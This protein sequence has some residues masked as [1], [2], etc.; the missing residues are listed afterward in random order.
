MSSI[1]ERL[2]RNIDHNQ[3][4]GEVGMAEWVH[5]YARVNGL[6]MHY[7]EQGEGPL[8]ILA[9]GFPQTW[10]SWHH[11]IPAIAAAGYR[12]VAFDQR[13]M[14]QTSAPT[15]PAEYD[16][17]HTAGDLVGLLDHL[18]EQTA[19]FAGLDFGLFAIYD[20]AYH[21]PERMTAIIGLENPAWPHD[22][23]RSPLA[24]AADMGARHFYHLHYFTAQPGV[25]DAALNAAP[26]AFLSK[27]FYALSGD[28]HYI[29]VWKHPPETAY[30]EALPEPP[31]LP[32]P[33]LSELEL[34]F[35]VNDYARSGF[36]G[37]LN[38]YRA[39]DLRW[40][41]RRRFEGVPNPVPFY[42]IGS[43][44]DTDLEAFHGEDPLAK[45]HQQYSALRAVEIIPHAGH[46]VQM[47][48]SR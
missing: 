17:P 15:D 24:E 4:A 20:M 40:Q 30:L 21:H 37:G 32:W 14:G 31:P 29:D 26:R 18:G 28:Y 16:V 41:Q 39:M 33:W 36:T 45:L 35:F 13:G 19:I 3:S 47:A 38:W 25:A 34:E 1:F 9:H 2:K 43:E 23:Q 22:P 27:V 10:F 44:N 42:F 8:V 5:R 11:Q 7:V 48:L 6:D 46:M 12:V